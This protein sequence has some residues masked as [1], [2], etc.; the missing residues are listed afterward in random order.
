MPTRFGRKTASMAEALF[1]VE[2][3]SLSLPDMTQKPLLG[4]APRIAI[5]KGLS[6]ALAENRITGIVGESGSGKTSLGRTLIRL[7]QPATR[8]GHAPPRPP[9]N[10][11][12]QAG[13]RPYPVCRTRH[14]GVQQ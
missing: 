14:C 11:P 9:C 5:L 1:E 8:A 4:S 13:L 7:P 10:P 2:G 12:A 3:L 6:F